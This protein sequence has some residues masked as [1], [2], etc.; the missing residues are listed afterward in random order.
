MVT[1]PLV[2]LSIVASNNNIGFLRTNHTHTH[3]HT[4]TSC[5]YPSLRYPQLFTGKRKPFRGILLYGPPGTGKSY[6]A[7]AVATEASST[8]FSVSSADLVSRWQG[9]SERLVRTLFQV[10]DFASRPLTAYYYYTVSC[11]SLVTCTVLQCLQ[12]AFGCS[13]KVVGSSNSA[14]V[15]SRP[16]HPA[17][18]SLFLPLPFRRPFPPR[19]PPSLPPILPLPLLPDG[20]R[21][22]PLGGV[23]GRGGLTLQCT[24]VR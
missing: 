18:S 10:K 14:F 2:T 8:F 3:T 16:I 12:S 20:S 15:S 11:S 21:Q 19:S 24:A 23:C 1:Y 7:A 4:H 22:L 9:E 13:M 5:P 6:L 17:P